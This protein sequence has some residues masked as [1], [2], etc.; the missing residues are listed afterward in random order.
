MNGRSPGEVVLRIRPGE[1]E[2]DFARRVAHTAPPTPTHVMDR[3]RALLA[4]T[5]SATDSSPPRRNL[6]HAA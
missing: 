5:A 2:T 6:H 1:S 3:L 4:P